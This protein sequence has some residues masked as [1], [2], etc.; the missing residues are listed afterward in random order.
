MEFTTII[1]AII[2]IVLIYI[3]YV[4]FVKTSSVISASASLKS[5]T[6][7]PIT[8]I[9]SGQ[10]TRYAYGIWV[11]V[12]TWDTTSIKTIF[13]RTGNIQLYL[14][15]NKPTLYCQIAQNPASTQGQFSHSKVGICHS[16]CR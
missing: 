1:L 10:S 4:Y 9:N 7:Q 5:S 6:N 14:A 12:N 3:L 11:Y 2:V 15:P 13:M 8:T 16:Q